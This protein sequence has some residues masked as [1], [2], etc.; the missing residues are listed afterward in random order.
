MAQS[1]GAN[2]SLTKEQA[3]LVRF[4]QFK[5]FFADFFIASEEYTMNGSPHFKDL[6][7]S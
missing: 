4:K 5:A 3:S 1:G 7:F 2:I 6:G